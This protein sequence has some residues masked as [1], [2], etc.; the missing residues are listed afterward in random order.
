MHTVADAYRFLPTLGEVDLHLFA[1]GRHERLWE[2]LGAHP[3]QLHHRRRRRRRRVVRGVGAQRQGRQPDRRLQPLE[4][5]RGADA[6]A[7]FDGGVGVVL[8]R[9]PR[10]T[11]CTSSG[12]TAPTASVTERADPMAFATEVP[13]Q[14]ASRV[15]DQRLHLGR[16][17]LDG[18]ARAAQSGVRADEHLRGAS[19]LVA[20]GPELPPARRASSPN[21]VVEHGFTHVEL[22]P[23]AEHPFGGSWGY[24]VTSYYAPTSRFGTPD[25]FRYLVD[26]SAPGRH[27]RASWTGCPRT[28]PRTRGRWA[29]STAPPLYEHSDP[30]PRR[31]TGLGH[32]RFRLRPRRRCATSWSPMRCTGCRSSTSTACG[33]TRSHRCSTSTTR[34]LR[35]AGRRTST[36]AGRTSRRC[37]SCRR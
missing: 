24:Q 27:R 18:A 2:V 34:G 30:R 33:W 16:R 37:S 25:E 5:Q 7:G 23:V 20:A 8:A 13:P 35:A 32:I 15:H 22:L 6:G 3:P 21:I 31:A 28:S 11:D 12:C 14:T 17:R 1:E 26:A 19:G 9:L 4:R 29:G 36:A 10:R